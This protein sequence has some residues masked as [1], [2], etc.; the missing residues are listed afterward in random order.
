VQFKPAGD[1]VVLAV[2]PL[3]SWT[4]LWLL[5]PVPGEGWR[6]DILPPAALQPGIGYAEF[7]GWVPATPGQAARLLLAREARAEGRSIKRFE[8]VSLESLDV[9]K[10]ASTPALLVAFGQNA[11]PQWRRRS[12]SLR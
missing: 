8:V 12:I 5:R 6:A 10:Q 9:L 2:Q 1:A 3:E 4:E 7:A 11:E